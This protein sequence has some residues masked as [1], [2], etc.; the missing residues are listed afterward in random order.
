MQDTRQAW[1]ICLTSK[2]GQVNF[3]FIKHASQFD[4]AI[5]K[6]RKI[7]ANKVRLSTKESISSNKVIEVNIIS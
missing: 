2:A 6:E 7:K 5:D 3:E 4:T 1:K